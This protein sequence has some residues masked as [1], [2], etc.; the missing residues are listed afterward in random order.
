MN[1]P[2]VRPLKELE[3]FKKVYLAPGEST[4]VTITLDRPSLAYYD[5]SAHAWDIARG[6]YRILVGSS[7]Q[8]LRLHG[9]S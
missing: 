2:V 1:P 5:V 3:G 8:D 6:V 4:R 7:S 9:V